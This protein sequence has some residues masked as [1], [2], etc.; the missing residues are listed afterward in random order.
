[1][2]NPGTPLRLKE[3]QASKKCNYCCHELHIWME[4][5]KDSSPFGSLMMKKRQDSYD[6]LVKKYIIEKFNTSKFS[7]NIVV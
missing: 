4:H 3:M 7:L 6:Y 2:K 1:M 5:S